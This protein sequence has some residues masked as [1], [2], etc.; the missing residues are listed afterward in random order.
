E[1]PDAPVESP[2]AIVSNKFPIPIPDR[3]FYLSNP[4]E[5]VDDY[6]ITVKVTALDEEGEEQV[7]EYRI[8]INAPPPENPDLGK[9]QLKIT[10]A[11]ALLANSKVAVGDPSRNSGA[12]VLIS[13][14]VGELNVLKVG[15]T[16]E[17]EIVVSDSETITESYQEYDYPAIV[18]KARQLTALL[19]ANPNL[20]VIVP[21]MVL[22]YQEVAQKVTL[23]H[24]AKYQF[25]LKGGSGGHMWTKK[26]NT[27][28][29]GKGG[30]VTAQFNF[31]ANTELAVRTGGEGEGTATYNS[32][33]NKYAK[34]NT[35]AGY[36]NS[37]KN[38]GWNGGGNGGARSGSDASYSAGGAGGGATDVRLWSD[39]ESNT[40]L[41]F[42][43]SDPRIAVAAG[44][45]GAAQASGSDNKAI[46]GGNGSQA[47]KTYYHN[48]ELAD[49]YAPQPGESTTEKGQDGL[50]GGLNEGRGGGGGG[51]NG[52]GTITTADAGSPYKGYSQNGSGLISSGA[53]GTNYVRSDRVSTPA[54]T[55]AGQWGNGTATITWISNNN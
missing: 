36:Y 24:N 21:E 12:A 45:G 55:V 50:S 51:F 41:T 47:G 6:M 54:L 23:A 40:L 1:N 29:G 44:G 27:A 7:N 11:E 10:E 22:S 26:S 49:T 48:S 38:G 34:L 53:G 18:A 8:S 35:P 13:N 52:G 30:H 20:V 43:G 5:G 19:N 14:V 42:N 25:D 9:V 4:P 28:P 32:S 3:T 37:T 16:K 46:P 15:E 33:E 17:R 31:N 2:L 39:S